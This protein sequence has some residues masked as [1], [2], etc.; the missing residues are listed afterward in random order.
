MDTRLRQ[1]SFHEGKRWKQ[2]QGEC[3]GIYSCCNHDAELCYKDWDDDWEQNTTG[4]VA[5]GWIV[6][7]LVWV[8]GLQ[9]FNSDTPATSIPFASPRR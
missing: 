9:H 6:C 3:N 8:F 5:Y 4:I 2:T 1:A 7:E